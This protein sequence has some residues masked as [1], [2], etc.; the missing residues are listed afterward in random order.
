MKEVINPRTTNEMFSGSE[1]SEKSVFNK[2]K[3]EAEM[4]VGIA[5]KKE[6]LAASSRLKLKPIIVTM[7]APARETPGTIA[8]DWPKPII[9]ASQ[10]LISL[11]DLLGL[12]LF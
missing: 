6:Y 11:I 5:R 4:I 7:T 2:S 8:K 9:M 10:G 1:T 12:I 3:T